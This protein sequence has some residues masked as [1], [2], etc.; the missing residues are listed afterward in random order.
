MEWK[1]KELIK[2]SCDTIFKKGFK[3]WITVVAVVFIF[4]FLGSLDNGQTAAMEKIDKALGL[5]S[6]LSTDNTENINVLKDYMRGTVIGEKLNSESYSFTDDMINKLSNNSAF[7]VQFI[8]M[9]EDYVKRNAGEVVG[10]L[11]ITMV[12]V[13]FI[14]FVITGVFEVGISRFILENRFQK[15]AKIRRIFAPFG[16]HNFWHIF[17]V[18]FQYLVVLVLWGFTIVGGII[19]FFQ[20][21]M[22]SFLLAENPK[23]KWKEAKK[24]SAEMT[25]GYKWKMFVTYLAS[26]PI[27]LIGFIPFVG[28]LISEPIYFQLKAEFYFKLRQR[29]DIDRK[30]FIEPVFDGPSYVAS[31]KELPETESVAD[32]EY[33][34]QDIMIHI[35]NFDVA[36]EYKVTDFIMMFFVFCLIG[37]LWEVSLHIVKDH[38]FVNRGMMYG[39]W[40]PIYGFGGVFIIFFLNR[41]KSSKPKLI[42]ST[43]LLCGV[44]EY[45]TS[46]VLDFT[47]NASYWNYKK[48]TFNLNGRICLAGLTAFAIGGFA[49]VYLLGPTIKSLLEKLGKTKTRI[50][51]VVLIAAFLIDLIVCMTVGPNSG[52]GVGGKMKSSIESVEYGEGAIKRISAYSL[53]TE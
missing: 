2:A 6:F 53:I 47:M 7:F 21:S 24:I 17:W 33:K 39:P 13:S 20:Y 28:T 43:M 41:F 26:I 40:I 31:R 15:V 14:G 45:F 30:A 10:F 3:A 49:G 8:F 11:I 23:L 25:K 9:N 4:T 36:D 37:W 52:K 42:I 44:L 32:P 48:F 1:H 35:T 27:Y 38:V 29:T 22:V 5:T 18:Y 51:C 34:M 19:K 46:L 50:V 16:D 12:L